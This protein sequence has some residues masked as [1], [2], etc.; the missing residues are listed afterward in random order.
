[1]VVSRPDQKT[2]KSTPFI[3]QFE[4]IRYT[5]EK[6]KTWDEF[7]GHSWNGVFLFYR[8]FMDYHQDRF[9]DYSL[10]VYKN[11]KLAA[12]LPCNEHDG[13]LISHQGLT[14]GG[15]V[16]APR[17]AA[18]DMEVLFD[19]V[20]TYLKANGIR[21]IDYKHKPPVF[22]KH[23]NDYD[24]WVLWKK[25]YSLWRRDL[26]FFIDLKNFAGFA[27]DKRYRFNKAGRNGLRVVENGNVQT[28]MSL[29]EENLSKKYHTK[30]VHSSSE[31]ELLQS[32]FPKNLQTLLVYQD[33][34][35]LG[36]TWLF[37][38]NDF[39]HT[40]YLHFNDVGRDLC[41][42]EFLVGYLMDSYPAKRY[43]SFGTSTEANGMVLNEG[44]ASF[45]EGFGASGFCHDFYR[46]ELCK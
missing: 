22:E 44:L 7:I 14:Y 32:R 46:K 39:I 19:E 24:S 13:V 21:Q 27:R 10:M 29:V 5:P 2:C 11:N 6:Q 38:D 18:A 16:L 41:A 23:S 40:Q 4:I 8:G 35:F 28:Y 42:A 34:T 17:F 20:E 43:L 12:V 37:S 31:V 26:S 9:N 15:W 33:D 45:K 36:G 1:M 30:P 3:M 25:G